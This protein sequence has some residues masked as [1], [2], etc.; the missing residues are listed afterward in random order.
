MSILRRFVRLCGQLFLPAVGGV[1]IVTGSLY[2]YLSPRLPSVESLRTVKLQIPLRIYSR[3][4][5][6]IGE[7]GE[8]KRTPITFE[9]IPPLFI[10]A[11]LAAEDDN[12]YSHIGVDIKGLLRAAVELL[13]TGKIQSG[14]STITMQL[15]RNFFLTREQSFIRKFNEILLALRIDGKLSKEEV[16]T[17]YCNLIYLGHRAY[18]I[19]AAA[20]AYYGKPIQELSLEQL[21]MIA[22]LPKAPSTFNPIANPVRAEERRNW[23]LGRMLKLGSID[24]SSYETAK[25]TPIKLYEHGPK[26]IANLPYVAEMARQQAVELMGVDAYSDGLS[27]TTTIDLHQ[28]DTAQQAV[29]NG[30]LAYDQR[31][32]YRGPERHIPD[33]RQWSSTLR[34]T[35]AYGNLE[36]AIVTRVSDYRADVLLAD[37]NTQSISWD[38]GLANLRPYIDE[39]HRGAAINSASTLFK[40]GD[41]VRVTAWEGGR[42][43]A[44][45]P[46]A[47]AALVA[48][49]PSNGAIRAVVGGFDFAQSHFNRAIQAKRQPGSSFKPFLYTVALERGFTPAT[50]VYDTPVVFEDSSLDKMWRPEN[51]NGKFYGPITLRKALYLSRNMVSIRLLRTI[52]INRAVNGFA[53]F[54]FSR[55]D[56]PRNLSLALGTHELTP[57]EI[58][59]GYAAFANGGYKIEPFLIERITDRDGNIVFAANPPTVCPDCDQTPVPAVTGLAA[60]QPANTPVP[61]ASTTASPRPAPRIMD[62]ATAYLMDSLLKDVIRRGTGK[63]ALALKRGDIAG[64]T[65]TTNG[66]RDAWF[67]GYNPTLVTT[68]WFGMDNSQLLGRGEYGSSA[69]LPIWMEFM[70]DA[71][72]GTPESYL[73]EPEGIVSVRI[74]PETGM[75]A[76]PGQTGVFELFRAN[77]APPSAIDNSGTNAPGAG[78][79]TVPED[80]F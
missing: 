5:Q 16:L 66:P 59:T 51:D 57:I 29:R 2:L 12:F 52:G 14:G 27:V 30:L 55:D 33:P 61:P 35:P 58:A 8:K 60:N 70:A 41:L 74:D 43:L 17:L 32:G 68:I 80:V 38:A 77:R 10:H 67:S 69:A 9:E 31:H 76:A 21:A 45:V 75:R 73:P 4:S 42:R 20:F 13:R 28:Q 46:N 56:M 24:T 71:L 18:G 65:G 50:I 63:K 19:Q 22:G 25:T 49:D 34:A 23:I 48:L 40:A 1:L 53:K 15:A 11:L 26:T 78:R 79:V 64:K 7:F 36:P 54:G 47:Q 39:D 37:G 3:D 62:A 72:R 44:Q 6:L